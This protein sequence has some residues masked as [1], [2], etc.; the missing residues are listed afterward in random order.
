MAQL[1]EDSTADGAEHECACGASKECVARACV[2]GAGYAVYTCGRRMEMDDGEGGGSP[3]FCF[4]AVSAGVQRL[5]EEEE[6]VHRLGAAGGEK[7]RK[8]ADVTLLRPRLLV[9]AWMRSGAEL[10]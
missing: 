8:V 5:F 6:D 1:A 4:H 2:W 7:I 3:R 9:A 10:L